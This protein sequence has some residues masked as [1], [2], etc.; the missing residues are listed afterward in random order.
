MAKNVVINGVTYSDVPSVEIPLSGSSGNAEFYDISDATISSGGSMLS[1]VTAYGSG[2]TKYTGSIT[3][4]TGTDLSASGFW[5]Y[6][7]GASRLLRIAA[8][9]GRERGQRDRTRHH[10]RLV[11]FAVHRNQHAHSEQDHQRHADRECWLRF[12]RHGWQL[13]CVPHG[14]CDH[15]G[16]GNNHTWHFESGNRGGN[17][18]HGQANYPG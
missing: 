9:K 5:R 2:G 11:G 1:G 7:H 16:G 8:D 6:R 18:S 12:E 14:I 13:V 3:T 4:K 15:Q 10:Q 17:V